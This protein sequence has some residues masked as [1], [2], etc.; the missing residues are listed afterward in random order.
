MRR[1]IVISIV[2]CVL[3]GAIVV[4]G[5]CSNSAN[6]PCAAV[7]TDNS[8][9]AIVLYPFY[10]AFSAR[11]PSVQFYV[12]RISAEGDFLLGGKGTLV[13]AGSWGVYELR[14]VSDG[15]GGAIVMWAPV[16]YG[17]G[18]SVQAHIAKI[19]SEGC[20]EWQRD[21]PGAE[22]AIPDGSGGVIVAFGDSDGNTAVLKID[23]EGNLPWGKDGVS[24]G[25]PDRYF[26]GIASDNLGGVIV[27]RVVVD[28]GRIIRAQRVDSDGKILWQPGGVRVCVCT[29]RPLLPQVTSDGS[30]G[31]IIAY[32]YRREEGGKWAIYAQRIDADGNVMWGPDGVPICM[33]VKIPGEV[34]M[35][36]D[37]AGGAIIFYR[38]RLELVLL[39]QRIDANGYKQWEYSL[40][41]WEDGYHHAV[42]DGSGGAI[43][44]GRR[45]AQRIDA[46]GRAMWGDNGTMV[47]DW[48]SHLYSISAD[49]CGGILICRVLRESEYGPEAAYVQRV[50]SEGKLV[51]GDE[52]IPLNRLLG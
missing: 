12:Q 15:S 48:V 17:W 14:A 46:R 7:T 22:K 8:G 9:G 24:V 38:G 31:A 37:G 47:L 25:L 30:G 41:G 49:G 52:G 23:A 44:V 5:S 50:D 32:N 1:K 43:D 10:R 29:G 4:A 51:W 6:I 28:E 13:G 27:A 35:V 42:S 11:G 40:R 26:G 33:E 21:I 19:D 36:E 39:A 20:I 16:K 2:I 3:V 34:G 18:A 45:K